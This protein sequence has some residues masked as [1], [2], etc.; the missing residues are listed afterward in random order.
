M[1]TSQAQIGALMDVM[2]MSLQE[3]LRRLAAEEEATPCGHPS[4]GRPCPDWCTGFRAKTLSNLVDQY[5]YEV[6]MNPDMS[7]F[8]EHLSR[9]RNPPKA[10]GGKMICANCDKE[11]SYYKNEVV[12]TGVKLTVVP[13]GTKG[14]TLAHTDG[15]RYCEEVR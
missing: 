4:Q 5:G 2:P 14:A 12:D 3:T 13:K 15:S 7:G 10:D 9:K 6:A 8:W 11:L 1:G